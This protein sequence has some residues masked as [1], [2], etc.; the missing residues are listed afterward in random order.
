M[1]AI[2]AAESYRVFVAA[3]NENGYQ[4][5][6]TVDEKKRLIGYEWTTIC[7]EDPERLSARATFNFIR[8]QSWLQ[9]DLFWNVY[10]VPVK[11]DGIETKI[12]IGMSAGNI[13]REFKEDHP[14]TEAGVRAAAFEV[15]TLL[16]R[17]QQDF[18]LLSKEP[19]WNDQ[20]LLMGKTLSKWLIIPGFGYFPKG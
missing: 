16:D 6:K 3:S 19:I 1:D 11:V 8:R 17:F 7:K 14:K 9:I 10:N 5:T 15:K 12:R 2:T 13:F 18:E 4:F 20:M